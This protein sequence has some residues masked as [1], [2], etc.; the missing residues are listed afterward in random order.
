VYTYIAICVADLVKALRAVN[1]FHILVATGN[2][3]YTY[4]A[5]CVADLV[6]ALKAAKS[7]NIL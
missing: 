4:I 1:R 6:K 7:F 2:F 3:V 5:I